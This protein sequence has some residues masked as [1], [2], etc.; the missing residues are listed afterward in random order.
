MKRLSISIL[1]SAFVS[2]LLLL[3]LPVYAADI[4]HSE[5]VPTDRVF[6]HEEGK[7]VAEYTRDRESSPSNP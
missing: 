3:A 2:L 1:I 7:K 5:L 6:V 4:K